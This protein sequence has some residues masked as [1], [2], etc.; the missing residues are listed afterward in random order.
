M[1]SCAFSVSV[2]GS[3]FKSLLCHHLGPSLSHYILLNVYLHN[4]FH[5]YSIVTTVTNLQRG[6][7]TFLSQITQSVIEMCRFDPRKFDFKFFIT[8]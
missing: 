1:C 6:K 3:E 8:M 5:P 2:G 4:L 7:L